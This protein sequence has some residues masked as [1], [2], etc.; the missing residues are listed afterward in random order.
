MQVPIRS[1]TL[2]VVVVPLCSPSLSLCSPALCSSALHSLPLCS[3]ALQSRCEVPLCSRFTVPFLQSLCSPALC[4]VPLTPLCCSPSAVPLQSLCSPALCSPSAV[5]LQSRS[6]QSRSAW[7]SRCDITFR[8]RFQSIH[9]T[10][11]PQFR[12]YLAVHSL[13]KY[14][15]STPSHPGARTGIPQGATVNAAGAFLYG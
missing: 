2:V 12:T 1:P 8:I 14:T 15:T 5:P 7:Q 10:L 9:K 3:P 11:K 4:T 13:F 6:L